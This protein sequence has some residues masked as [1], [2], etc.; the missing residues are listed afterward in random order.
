METTLIIIKPD[1]IRRGLA[2][3]ILKRIEQKG[4]QLSAAKLMEQA[5]RHYQEHRDKCFYKGLI[6][7]I[8]SSPVLAMVW[9]GKEAVRL[10][11]LLIGDTNVLE[12][13]SGTIRGD[14][15]NDIEK[16]LVHGSDS[17]ES[18]VWEIANL[19]RSEE[20]LV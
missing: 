10:C 11:R 13:K 19:F 16:N 15:G 18:A 9:K 4:F 7:Y 17:P 3:E 6:A 5:E 12:A 20:L 1:G 8:T 14:F 2:G